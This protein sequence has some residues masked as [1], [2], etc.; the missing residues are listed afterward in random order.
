MSLTWHPSYDR[1]AKAL[2]CPICLNEAA[3]FETRIESRFT[4]HFMKHKPGR[5]LSEEFLSPAAYMRVSQAMGWKKFIA[6]AEPAR[7]TK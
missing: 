7:S 1:Q 3:S 6:P 4:T 2:V 5:E